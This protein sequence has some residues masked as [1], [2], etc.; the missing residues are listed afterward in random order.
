[1]VGKKTDW[2]SWTA[3]AKPN[4]ILHFID[5]FYATNEGE[6]IREFIA[7]L[8]KDTEYGLVAIEFD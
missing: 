1:M 8:D 5:Q 3:K 2:G 7:T 4:A 6:N